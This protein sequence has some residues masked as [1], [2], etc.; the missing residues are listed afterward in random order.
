MCSLH[1]ISLTD[2][3]YYPQPV[4]RLYSVPLNTFTG[5]D[6]EEVEAEETEEQEDAA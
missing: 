2:K 3:H 5:E 4:I 6:E 1:R